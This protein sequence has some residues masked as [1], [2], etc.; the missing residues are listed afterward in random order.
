M[1]DQKKEDA[2]KA[3]GI[4]ID[5]NRLAKRLPAQKRILPG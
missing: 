5:L 2:T 4:V 3:S 1:K